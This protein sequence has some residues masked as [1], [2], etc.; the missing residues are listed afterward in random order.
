MASL[1]VASSAMLDWSPF[2]LSSQA[3]RLSSDTT[4]V[5]MVS[6]CQTRSRSG[7]G[8]CGE[9]VEQHVRPVLDVL[10]VGVLLRAVAAPADA[11]YEDHAGR[12]Q[13]CQVLRVVAR[14]GGQGA[15]HQTPVGRRL[16]DDLLDP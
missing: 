16:A 1:R 2:A 4:I 8:E 7:V 11:G 15:G 9:G 12:R 5:A 3:P 13:G 10:P 6:G 14:A